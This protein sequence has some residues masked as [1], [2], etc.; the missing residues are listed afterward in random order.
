MTLFTITGSLTR[1][2]SHNSKAIIATI[3]ISSSEIMTQ[4]TI[5]PMELLAALILLG[6][7]PMSSDTPESMQGEEGLEL[8]MADGVVGVGVVVG[9]VKGRGVGEGAVAVVE[10]TAIPGGEERYEDESPG[11]GVGE[12]TVAV[13]VYSH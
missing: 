11:V 7:S 2:L 8:R 10:T 9:M 4:A 13:V 12:V 6:S 1:F 5:M 3:A